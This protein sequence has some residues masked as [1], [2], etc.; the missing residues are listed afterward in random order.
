[1]EALV[2]KQLL[3]HPMGATAAVGGSSGKGDIC[4]LPLVRVLACQWASL[5]LSWLF[6]WHRFESFCIGLHGPK[7]RIGSYSGPYPAPP[8]PPLPFSHPVLSLL[9]PAPTGLPTEGPYCQLAILLALGCSTD[10][11]GPSA[12]A[13]SL[14]YSTFTTPRASVEQ[15]LQQYGPIGL[16][17]HLGKITHSIVFS[18]PQNGWQKHPEATSSQTR[19]YL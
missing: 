12:A 16:G 15:Q 10:W 7:R 4:P 8:A 14:L 19:S 2:P 11:R 1:M 18:R 9:F 13:L 3:L 6:C 17:S 5:S